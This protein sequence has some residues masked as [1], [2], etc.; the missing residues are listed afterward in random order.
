MSSKA[1][2]LCFKY[3]VAGIVVF[4]ATATLS[5]CAYF[6]G[7]DGADGIFDLAEISKGIEKPA[8]VVEEEE[9]V[10]EDEVSE[11]AIKTVPVRDIPSRV[12][13]RNPYLKKIKGAQ[14]PPEPSMEVAPGEGVL[15]NFDN[16]DVY[17]VIQVIAEILDIS[18]IIDPQVKGVVNIRSGKKIP[19]SQLYA[20]FK[21]LLNIN[22]LDIRSEGDYNYI[23]SAKKPSSEMVQGPDQADSLKESPSIMIQIVPVMHIP[24]AEAVKL[25]K[26][27][28]SEQGEMFTLENPNTL[29]VSDYESKVLDVLT[30][31]A[32]LDVSP[33]SSLRVRLVRIDKAPIFE[34]KDELV[35]I[36]SSLQVNSKGYDGVSV[37]ALERV[38]SLLL[39]SSNQELLDSATRWVTELDVVPSEGRDNIYIYNVRNS[40][41]SDLASLVNELISSSPS[42]TTGS[43]AAKS[44]AKSSEEKDSSATPTAITK[45]AKSTAVRKTGASKK[46]GETGESL[47]FAG[48]PVIIADDSRNI[49]LLRA[50]PADYVRLTKLLER[51][52]NIPRQVLIEVMVAEVNL[53]DSWAMGIEWG[54]KETGRLKL[55]GTKYTN[56]YFSNLSQIANGESGSPINHDSLQ[57]VAAGFTYSVLNSAGE[58]MGILNAIADDTELTILS[59]PQVMVLNNETAT[60]NV[61]QQVPIVTSQTGDINSSNLNQTIQY[62]DTGVILDVTPKINYDGII[63]LDINQQVSSASTNTLS[64]TESPIISNRE[65]KT[66]LAVRD[67]QTIFMG[68]LIENNVNLV[69]SGVPFLKDIPILGWF[70]K[71]QKEVKDKTELLVMITPYV[72][73]TEDVLAQYAANFEKKMIDLRKKLNQGKK[74]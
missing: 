72:I 66:K 7:G 31:L 28:L 42:V 17:E 58:A 5:G 54:M 70:F 68:G 3:F 49:I 16:A 52:D 21:K 18:Y 1:A 38:N 40:V 4:L 46:S 36:L 20:V 2:Q 9:K 56:K 11:T 53:N 8:P 32:R 13:G 69:D 47:R 63:I 35:E 6:S 10:P 15:L 57:S 55:D 27:Y 74:Q 44:S 37:L 61:G 73:E 34:L 23:F 65:L 51:L 43:S 19:M 45:P 33:L 14:P 67:G 41:A 26:P 71:Y 59:S 12:D 48:E 64:G 30:I 25:L 50:H 62:K 29:F 60:V 39:V 22:G 24:V